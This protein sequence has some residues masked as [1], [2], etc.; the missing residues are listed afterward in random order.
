MTT[1]SMLI[2]QERAV[3]ERNFALF[4]KNVFCSIFSYH[5]C[6]KHMSEVKFM[7]ITKYF[8]AVGWVTAEHDRKHDRKPRISWIFRIMTSHSIQEITVKKIYE[9]AEMPPIS[10]T[11]DISRESDINLRAICFGKNDL[12]N[13]SFWMSNCGALCDETRFWPRNGVTNFRRPEVGP[14][15]KEPR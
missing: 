9:I 14:K 5:L 15:R 4:W 7:A 13:N 2:L 1:G 12:L 8:S 11:Q 3:K 10:T 6:A